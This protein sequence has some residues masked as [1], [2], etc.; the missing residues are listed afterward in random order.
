AGVD[1]DAGK[2]VGR[3]ATQ[4]HGLGAARGQAGHIHLLRI[5]RVLRVADETVDQVEQH[6]GVAAA[7]AVGGSG[8]VP[9]VRAVHVAGGVRRQDHGAVLVGHAFPVVALVARAVDDVAG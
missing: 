8:P 5:D 3:Q 7:A 9:A 6:A 2:D 1:A 4:H